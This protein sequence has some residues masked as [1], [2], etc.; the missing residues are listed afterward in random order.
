MEDRK[1]AFSWALL[2]DIGAGRPNLGDA[3]SVRVYRLMQYTFRDVLEQRYGT[4]ATDGLFLEAGKLAGMHFYKNM[5]AGAADFQQL[6]QMLQESFRSLGVGVIRV[7][8]ADP[9]FEEIMLSVEEDADCSGLPE[10]DYE[11]CRYD[12]GFIAGILE[13][14]TGR[15]YD[16]REI[17]CWCT[18][19]RA[20]R[21][22]AKA[23]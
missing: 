8:K 19:G 12:E 18:G 7:E 22:R 15:P 3:I 1:Y 2:G 20:C 13:G 21:F 14:F 4:E 17:D 23:M 6:V 5:I 11:F 10:L 9:P 16:V